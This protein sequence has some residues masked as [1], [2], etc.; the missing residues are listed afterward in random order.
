MGDDATNRNATPIRP[1]HSVCVECGSEFGGG[2]AM[3]NGALVCPECGHRQ[4]LQHDRPPREKWI[5]SPIV[6]WGGPVLA[7]LVLA[8]MLAN[9]G[10]GATRVAWIAQVAL[11]CIALALLVWRAARST[12]KA[13]RLRQR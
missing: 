1:K 12:R 13:R 2:V 8:G 4:D 7:A 10:K 9:G 11:T 3:E 5:G 6:I